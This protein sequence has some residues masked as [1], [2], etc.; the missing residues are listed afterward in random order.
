TP[1]AEKWEQL[2]DL[3]EPRVGIA[4]PCPL[5]T[6]HEFFLIGGYA[7]VFPGAPRE[8]PGFSAQT[9]F[10]DFARQACRNGPVLPHAPVPDRD[11]PGDVGPAPMI[12]APCVVWHGEAIVIGGE[13]RSSVR[14]PTVLA[15]PLR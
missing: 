13:V 2:A 7:E 11:A 9:Y 12:G 8:H 3:P 14:T 5:A 1:G 15:W 10:Y 6:E 4:S